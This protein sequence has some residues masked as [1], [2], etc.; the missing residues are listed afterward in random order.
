MSI[1]DAKVYFSGHINIVFTYGMILDPKKL[2]QSERMAKRYNN[3]EDYLIT[4]NAS[5]TKS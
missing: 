4:T 3:S 5:T 1:S 2:I